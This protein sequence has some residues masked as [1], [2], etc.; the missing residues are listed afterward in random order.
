VKGFGK[1]VKPKLWFRMYLSI[2]CHIKY[3]MQV[4]GEMFI[5]QKKGEQ[6]MR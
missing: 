3:A 1:K 2:V 4:M 5:K 6:R